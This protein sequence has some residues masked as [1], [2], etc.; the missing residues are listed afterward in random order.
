MTAAE[1]PDDNIAGAKE[2]LPH[3][4]ISD[5]SPTAD[6]HSVRE[7]LTRWLF[8]LMSPRG[9]DT[10]QA[11]E[12]ASEACRDIYRDVAAQL[13]EVVQRD[14]A[15]GRADL[16]PMLAA[17]DNALRNGSHMTGGN[18][19]FELLCDRLGVDRDRLVFRPDWAATVPAAER[20]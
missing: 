6:E 16:L 13:I 14:P 15:A 20:G 17:V 5:I 9:V 4:G 19:A 12:N 3:V 1:I 10:A 7:R 11:W 2:A 18:L 8:T